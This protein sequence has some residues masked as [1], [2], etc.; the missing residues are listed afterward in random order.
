MASESDLVTLYA[1][2]RPRPVVGVD[3]D[4]REEISVT[5]A[6]YEEARSAVDA[7]VPDGWQ[8]LGLSRWPYH[9]TFNEEQP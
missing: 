1:S 9:D 4:R 8:L 6:T 2:A 3:D 5:R 7:R